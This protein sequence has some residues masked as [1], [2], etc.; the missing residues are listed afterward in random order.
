MC[1]SFFLVFTL[2]KIKNE[3]IMAPIAILGSHLYYIN[4]HLIS[5]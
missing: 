4:L 1:Q 2:N 5:K 3:P